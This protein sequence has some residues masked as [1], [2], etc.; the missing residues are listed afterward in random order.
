M[1]KKY[2]LGKRRI[3]NIGNVNEEMDYEFAE[4]N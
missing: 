2:G 3:E 4:R 1:R